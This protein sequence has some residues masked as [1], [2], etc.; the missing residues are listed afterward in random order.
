[1]SLNLDVLEEDIKL[2]TERI[3]LRKPYEK[4]IQDISY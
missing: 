2:Q 3:L 4:D 1:M